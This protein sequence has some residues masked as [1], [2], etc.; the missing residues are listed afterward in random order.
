MA[1]L[2]C[3]VVALRECFDPIG[4]LEADEVDPSLRIDEERTLHEIAMRGKQAE[5]VIDGRGGELGFEV[6]GPVIETGGVEEGA[7]VAATCLE[8]GSKLGDAGWRLADR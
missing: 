7:E 5:G 6:H 1:T 8:S 4:F 3:Q 2:L